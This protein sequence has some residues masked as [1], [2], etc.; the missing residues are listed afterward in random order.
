MLFIHLKHLVLCTSGSTGKAPVAAV[1]AVT[2][3][4]IKLKAASPVNLSSAADSTSILSN[5]LTSEPNHILS[6]LFINGWNFLISQT[7]ILMSDTFI[8][9]KNLRKKKKPLCVVHAALRRYSVSTVLKKWCSCR[10]ML[11]LWYFSER[12]VLFAR[13]GLLE[14]F[15]IK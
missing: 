10:L 7:T 4:F 15:F 5:G 1:A 12:K 3:P 14:Y 6:S 11:L 9:V 2:F 8:I 13:S